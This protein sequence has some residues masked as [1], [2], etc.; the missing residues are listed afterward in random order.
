[1]DFERGAHELTALVLAYF[2]LHKVVSPFMIFL[3]SVILAEISVPKTSEAGTLISANITLIISILIPPEAQQS[4][5]A[6][7]YE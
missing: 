2:C 1:M 4:S 6:I 5:G 7:N 3:I